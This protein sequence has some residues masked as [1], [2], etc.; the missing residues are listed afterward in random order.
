MH[1]LEN[2][3]GKLLDGHYQNNDK[4]DTNRET[5][6]FSQNFTLNLKSLLLFNL[7][8][9]WIGIYYYYLHKT[10]KI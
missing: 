8:V 6:D 4:F 3:Y 5:K 1:E 2:I 10:T 9:Y 7:R